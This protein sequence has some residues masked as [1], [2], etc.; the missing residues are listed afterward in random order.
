[1]LAA[2]MEL[3]HAENWWIKISDSHIGIE[4]V[5]KSNNVYVATVSKRYRF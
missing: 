4:M 1:M 5:F 2:T 3:V